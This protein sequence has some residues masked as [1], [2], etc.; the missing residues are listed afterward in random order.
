MQGG[1]SA[2]WSAGQ[3]SFR[4]HAIPTSEPQVA[5]NTPGV[6]GRSRLPTSPPYRPRTASFRPNSRAHSCRQVWGLHQGVDEYGQRHRKQRTCMN[7]TAADLKDLYM[8]CSG[9]PEKLCDY[10]PCSSQQYWRSPCIVESRGPHHR[11][12]QI[13]KHVVKR[14]QSSGTVLCVASPRNMSLDGSASS[15]A[16]RGGYRSQRS[17]L[18]AEAAYSQLHTQVHCSR[19]HRNMEAVRALL[20]ERSTLLS[21]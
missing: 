7:S 12:E 15:Y 5:T 19:V 2:S 4:L 21:R 11:C 10:V 3:R 17:S 16:T 6:S 8:E 14:V 9:S 18:C 1:G 20:E 13:P